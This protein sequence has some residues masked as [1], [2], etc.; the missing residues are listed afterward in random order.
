M[1]APNT[2]EKCSANDFFIEKFTASSPNNR[3]N[4]SLSNTFWNIWFQSEV[5]TVCAAVPE[6][7]GGSSPS[8]APSGHIFAS[9]NSRDIS[10][11]KRSYT[12]EVFKPISSSNGF[13]SQ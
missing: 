7:Q 11:N 2:C 13:D 6:I 8:G 1:A 12:P 5:F 10:L 3:I 4:L 9:S